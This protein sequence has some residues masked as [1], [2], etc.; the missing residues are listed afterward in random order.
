MQIGETFYPR[1]R[2]Q[3]RAW[4]AKRHRSAR[5]IW[6]VYYKKHTGKPSV[7][8]AEAVEEALCFGWIDSTMKGIDG[9]KFA[10][11]F[12]PRR[13]GSELSELNKE[14]IRRLRRAKKMTKFGL[15]QVEHAFREHRTRRKEPFIIPGAIRRALQRDPQVW[16]NFCAFPEV[17]RRIR[18]GWL[19]MSMHRPEIFRKRLNYF[20]RMTAKNR[21]YG[22][23]QK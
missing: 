4:L 20:L 10:Q 5:E 12:T 23:I 13:F 15:A 1:T 18:I 6:L 19:A 2:A 11:R 16:K 21:R 14:R 7:P 9:T 17:Y 8:Y 22:S 3:W